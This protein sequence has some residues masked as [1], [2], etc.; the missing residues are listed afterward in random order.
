MLMCILYVQEVSKL[1]SKRPET[2]VHKQGRKASD[3]KRPPSDNGAFIV[4][5]E[6]LVDARETLGRQCCTELRTVQA[7]R[8]EVTV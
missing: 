2:V 1:P 8:P 6:L 7:R 3:N 5:N 4:Y